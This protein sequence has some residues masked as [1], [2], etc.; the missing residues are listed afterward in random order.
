MDDAVRDGAEDNDLSR[1]QV[2]EMV[3]NDMIHNTDV[4]DVSKI[5]LVSSKPKQISNFDTAR[6]IKD[7]SENLPDIKKESSSVNLLH[8]AKEAIRAK[9][10]QL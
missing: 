4:S 8:I 3:L 2:I 7:I 10:K 9:K 6:L 5:Y 1:D